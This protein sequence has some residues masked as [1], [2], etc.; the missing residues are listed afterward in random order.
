MLSQNYSSALKTN[1]EQLQRFFFLQYNI[2]HSIWDVI[3]V[4]KHIFKA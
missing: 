2:A 1:S 3:V 4:A